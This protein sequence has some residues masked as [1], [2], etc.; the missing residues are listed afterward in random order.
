MTYA[1]QIY[2]LERIK[3]RCADASDGIFHTQDGGDCDAE[4]K[5]LA[6]DG[7]IEDLASPEQQARGLHMWTLATWSPKKLLMAM[8]RC[9]MCGNEQKIVFAPDDASP[10]A[11]QHAERVRA[12]DY[13][14]TC[15]ERKG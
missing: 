5:A 14:S 12:G 11:E 13:C 2:A 8:V 15:R 9:L 1:K 4:C 10:L 3:A 6:N 7:L